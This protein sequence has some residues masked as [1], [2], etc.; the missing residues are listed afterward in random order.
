MVSYN[1]F[2]K[3]SRPSLPLYNKYFLDPV[4][5]LVAIPL[6]NQTKL[7]PYHI[8]FIGFFV[9]LISAYLFWS[10]M[11]ILA[12]SIFQISVVLDLV[13]GYV[14]KAKK[15]GT[16]FGILLDGYADV[17]RHLI[18]IVALASYSADDTG[19]VLLLLVFLYLNAGESQI[20]KEFSQV[21]KF[22][23]GQPEI[24][25]SR[26]ELFILRLSKQ[27][28]HWGIRTILLY[29]QERIFCVLFLGP[30]LG[31]IPFWTSVGIILVMA[32]I[33]MRMILDVALIKENIIVSRAG[34]TV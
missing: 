30:V 25:L 1:D 8:T 21:R 17:F 20:A 15:N 9:S 3:W 14:A 29:Y 16:T 5:R 23:I 27:M 11:L 33:H 19:T 28:G 22:L 32:S 31:N 24:T 6:I 26:V 34:S 12:A 18:N 13:D 4:A 7:K 10:G 2:D